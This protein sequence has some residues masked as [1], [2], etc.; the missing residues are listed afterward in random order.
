MSAREVILRFTQNAGQVPG[1]EPG[2]NGRLRARFMDGNHSSL[3]YD[4][5]QGGRIVEI[6]SYGPHFPLGRLL[7]N[8]Q[9]ERR[10]WVLNGDSWPGSGR[11]RTNHHNAMMRE[12][13][14]QSG[15]PWIVLPAS[16]LREAGIDVDTI[17]P[18]TVQPERWTWEDHA[19]ATL[20]S[21]PEHRR[22]VTTWTDASGQVITPP[23]AEDGQE[24]YTGEAYRN[25]TGSGWH[26]QRY[27]ALTGYQRIAVPGPS[28]QGPLSFSQA[29]ITP[30][31]DGLYH[32]RERHHQRAESVFRARYR[33][34]RPGVISFMERG[35]FLSAFD[36]QEPRPLR[37]LAE[38]PAGSYA[39]TVSASREVLKP[40]EVRRAEAAG[41]TVLRQGSMFAIPAPWPTRQLRGPS[42]RKAPVLG[43]SYRATEVRVTSRG[44]TY[45]R[46]FLRNARTPARYRVLQLGDRKQWHL[47][48]HGA[49]PVWASSA[50]I[51]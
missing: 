45:A 44:D 21:V 32:W 41:I 11:G 10:L 9:G 24:A 43:T 8:D 19:A 20:D 49:D 13:A 28:F 22:M 38:L 26:V 3:Y 25:E 37:F 7:L 42:L 2:R 31:A 36:M 12:A 35:C 14:Q 50:R 46:G 27:S 1:R 17:V 5:D 16:A 39:G 23:R 18:V 33:R 40:A 4:C 29:E 15:T 30:G 48:L 34:Y 51:G 6:Q 47:M